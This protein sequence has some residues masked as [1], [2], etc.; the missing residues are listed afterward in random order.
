[1]RGMVG[2]RVTTTALICVASAVA[3]ADSV[4]DAATGQLPQEICPAY[5]LVETAGADDP[6]L[7]ADGLTLTTAAALENVFYVQPFD[8]VPAEL[9]VTARM[10]LVAGSGLAG[11]R[12]PAVVAITSAPNSGTLFFIDEGE[13][14]LTQSGDLKGPSAFIDTTGGPHTYRLA[15]TGG[16]VVVSVDGVVVMNGFTYGSDDA[17]GSE[18]GILW[19]EGFDEAFGTSQ[20]ESVEHDGAACGTMTSST[21]TSPS[22]TTFPVTTTFSPT[23]TF[24]ITTTFAITT[25]FPI[26][27]TSPAATTFPMTTT[28]PVTTT[29]SPSTTFPVTTTSPVTTTFAVTTTFPP[30]TTLTGD[31]ATEPG[32]LRETLCGLISLQTRL[33]LSTSLAPV[34]ARAVASSRQAVALGREAADACSLRETQQASQWLRRL[35]RRLRV[36]SRQLRLGTRRTRDGTW[37]GFVEESGALRRAVMALR[38]G[39]PCG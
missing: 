3:S 32:V 7:G 5:A 20:W 19:G 28:F 21:T 17:F 6:A 36:L 1:M 15:I 25:T 39:T 37:P 8:R 12:G 13:V 4:W 23:T 26:T 29:F 10:Q 35:E 30:I 31:C 18:P 33:S 9:E 11:N 22:T 2:L 16:L 34:R 24:P 38:N 14:F 27:T